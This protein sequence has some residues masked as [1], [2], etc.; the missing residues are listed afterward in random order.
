MTSPTQDSLFDVRPNV[1]R[2]TNFMFCKQYRVVQNP[3]ETFPLDLSASCA[4]LYSLRKWEKCHSVGHQ[5]SH[6]FIDT[7]FGSSWH[8]RFLEAVLAYHSGT[9]WRFLSNRIWRL[10]IGWYVPQVAKYLGGFETSATNHPV[11]RLYI[12]EGIAVRN[13][14][15]PPICLYFP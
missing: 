4:N 7:K 13:L 2:G 12:R 1:S 3:L 9:N 8:L 15:G 14:I 5:T 10:V 6:M 11:T